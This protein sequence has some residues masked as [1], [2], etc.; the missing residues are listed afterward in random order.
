MARS[1]CKPGSGP[2]EVTALPPP[3]GSV[4]ISATDSVSTRLIQVE[5]CEVEVA[6]TTIATSDEAGGSDDLGDS[7]PMHDVL[8]EVGSQGP[9]LTHTKP[10][11]PIPP[12]CAP[13]LDLVCDDAPDVKSGLSEPAAVPL[14]DGKDVAEG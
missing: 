13:L 2:V 4:R 11:D 9:T 6:D 14:P 8:V 3:G 10:S 7:T 1:L 5:G 12:L